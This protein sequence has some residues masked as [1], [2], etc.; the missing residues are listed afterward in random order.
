MLLDL[1]GFFPNA[2]RALIVERHSEL[3][4]DPRLRELADRAVL[5]SPE[6]APGHGMALGL[7]LSQIEMTAL[8]TAIDQW[9]KCQCHIAACG[10]YMD[11]YYVI[12]EDVDRLKWIAAQLIDRFE[13]AGIPVN[14]NKVHIQPL[15]KPFRF[16]KSRFT[17]TQ[18]GGIIV[19]R[20]RDGMKR[21]RRKF[22]MFRRA[23]DAGTHTMADVDAFMESERAYYRQYNDH[24][25][26]LRLERLY[27]AIFKEG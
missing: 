3:I 10:H 26:L 27:H 18:A 17:L 2:N 20:C 13:A 22:R 19:N 1:A 7:E 25:R 8:P 4:D 5:L 11:D 9:L 12:C 21:A 24:G 15:A 14:R 6:T 23:I 16:C